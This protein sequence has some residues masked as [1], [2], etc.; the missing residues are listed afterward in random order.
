MEDYLEYY[1]KNKKKK[2]KAITLLKVLK[3]NNNYSFLELNPLTGRK[4]QLRKQLF[5]RGFPIIGDL[6]Y[7]LNFNK[8]IKV[9]LCCYMLL[10]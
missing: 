7:N 8:K 9:S 5:L 10:V 4:H 2:L 1:E 3:S 6:K